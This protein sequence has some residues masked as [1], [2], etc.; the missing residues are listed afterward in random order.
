[1][2]WMT[3]NE[4]RSQPRRFDCKDCGKCCDKG[5]E[6]E[7]VEAESLAGNFILFTLFKN[8]SRQLNE[9]PFIVEPAGRRNSGPARAE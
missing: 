3:M 1:M 5:P 8:H 4:L 9:R 2:K 6:I 7:N